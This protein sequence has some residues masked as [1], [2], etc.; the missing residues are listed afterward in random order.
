ML[1]ISLCT[2]C[3]DWP[4]LRRT[5]PE[6]M[7]R[8]AGRRDVEYCVTDLG[9]CDDTLDWLVDQSIRCRQL[10][11]FQ[12]RCEPLHF[13]RAYNL[14]FA[15]ATGDV[16]VCLDADNVIGLRFLDT[17]QERL[18][19]QPDT[20]LHVWSGDWSDGTCGRLVFPRHIFQA[21]GGYD[22]SLGLCGFQ[23]ID[24]RDRAQAAG[25]RL[26]NVN[27]PAV[28]GSAVF[29]PDPEKLQHLDGL[30][31]QRDNARNCRISQANIAA[32]K[33]KANQC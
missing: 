31:Y 32:Q 8:V 33:L 14:A 15:S 13:A 21:L 7:V 26:V 9:S 17:V 10:R 19:D 23:D 2:W 3:R 24:L 4:P 22:E 12:K 16:L 11:V 29:T 27:E 25:Y 30:N 28:V 18:A 20:F 6:N 5:L 1:K